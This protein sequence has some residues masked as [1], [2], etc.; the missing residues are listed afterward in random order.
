[1]AQIFRRDKAKGAAGE[2]EKAEVRRS[3]ERREIIKI[4]NVIRR[5]TASIIKEAREGNASEGIAAA[6]RRKR[7]EGKGEEEE[8]GEG[9][10][11]NKRRKCLRVYI[12]YCLGAENE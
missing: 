12:I 5:Q 8:E 1:M 11:G 3:C 4:G 2:D 6:L 9:D 10:R 7:S